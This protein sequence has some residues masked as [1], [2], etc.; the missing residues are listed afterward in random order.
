MNITNSNVTIDNLNVYNNTLILFKICRKWNRIKLIIEYIKN[1]STSDK[2]QYS[3]K[4]SE[5][6]TKQHNRDNNRQINANKIYNE[7]NVN[8]C[9]ICKQKNY[10]LNFINV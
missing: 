10:I 9:S 6:I 7:N 1:K 4:L 5:S 2:L 3:C 8:T